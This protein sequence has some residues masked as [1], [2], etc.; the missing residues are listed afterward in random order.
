[1]YGDLEGS[2]ISTEIQCARSHLRV[3]EIHATIQ[4]QR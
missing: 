4:G 2:R 1:M 3:E